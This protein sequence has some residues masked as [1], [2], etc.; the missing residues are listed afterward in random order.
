MVVESIAATDLIDSGVTLSN[1]T[2]AMERGPSHSKDDDTKE[3][4]G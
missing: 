2:A 3:A 4:N 1:E